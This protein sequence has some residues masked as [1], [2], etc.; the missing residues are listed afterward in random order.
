MPGPRHRAPG[1]VHGQLQTL[2]EER[3]DPGH[4]PLPGALA[5][6]VDVAVVGVPAEGQSAPLQFAVQAG[7][8]RCSTAAATAARPAACPVSLPSRPRRP[9]GPLAGSGGSGSGRACPQSSWRPGAS[10]RRGSHGRRTSP[11]P[12][13]P[14]SACRPGCTPQ[15]GAPPAPRCVPDGSRSARERRLEDRLHHLVQGLLDQPFHHGGHAQCPHPALRLGNIHPAYRSRQVRPVKQRRPSIPGAPRLLMT[16]LYAFCLLLP[17]TTCS[18]SRRPSD[19]V[20]QFVA[21]PTSAPTRALPGFRPAASRPA[22]L[23]AASASSIGFKIDR[24]TLGS[25]RSALRSVPTPTM[26]PADF[27]PRIPSPLDAGS[28][29]GHTTRSPQVLRTHLHAYACRIYAAPFR[30]RFGLR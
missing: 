25:T 4:D 27:W 10:A 12:C 14:P 21:A 29:L 7:Q 18:M 16:R 13:P 11:G 19:F 24:P 23:T 1:R 6:Y 22:R 9:P 2:R 5:G 30:A 3:R 20:R 8:T 15:P 28:P 26:A 17:S